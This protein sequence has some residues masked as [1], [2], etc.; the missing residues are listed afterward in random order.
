V[1][2]QQELFL[3]VLQYSTYDG[4]AW[5]FFAHTERVFPHSNHGLVRRIDMKERQ[6]GH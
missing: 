4:S 2:I 1:N 5:R 6:L 3:C